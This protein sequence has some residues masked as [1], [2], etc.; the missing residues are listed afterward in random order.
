VAEIGTELGFTDKS[1]FN[2]YFKGI[3][4]YYS[5]KLQKADISAEKLIVFLMKNFIEIKN[6]SYSIVMFEKI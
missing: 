4:A 2:K 5:G 6:Y 3:C 1:N